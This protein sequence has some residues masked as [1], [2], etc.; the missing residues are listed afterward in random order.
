MDTD[1]SGL[2]VVLRYSRG[3]Y[4]ADAVTSFLSA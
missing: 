1:N 3:Q 2:P 4:A